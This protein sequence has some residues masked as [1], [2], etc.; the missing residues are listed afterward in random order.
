MGGQELCCANVRAGIRCRWQPK[1]EE[2]RPR[3]ASRA[4]AWRNIR[5]W[6]MQGGN[7]IIGLAGRFAR[8]WTVQ[9]P[10]EVAFGGGHW[11]QDASRLR[12]H[13]S[14]GT[15]VRNSS[16]LL[17]TK[18]FYNACLGRSRLLQRRAP[19]LT[20]QTVSCPFDACQVESRTEIAPCAPRNRSPGGLLGRAGHCAAAVRDR[21]PTASACGG[22]VSV[23]DIGAACLLIPHAIVR[24][25]VHAR[26]CTRAC[27]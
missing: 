13:E 24:C 16:W 9:F 8:A 21:S 23:H 18:S 3:R 12:Q 10:M 20:D 22:P 11:Q 4:S 1:S 17:S 6:S 7:L 2:R 19:W 5:A 27:L 14:Q 15:A 26:R 25:R